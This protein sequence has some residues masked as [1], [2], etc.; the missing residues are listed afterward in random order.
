MENIKKVCVSCQKEFLVVTQEQEFLA[1]M[2][3]PHP[4]K[5]PPCRQEARLKLRGERRL[6]RTT[7]QKCNKSIIVTYDPAKETRQI[8]C[9]ECYLDYLEKQEIT[10]PKT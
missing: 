2:G 3:L 9:K 5:C 10:L 4:V 7:C 8:F 6:Y 1:K